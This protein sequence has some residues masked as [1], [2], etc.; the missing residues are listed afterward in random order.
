MVQ[1]KRWSRA[2]QVFLEGLL[3]VL[4]A[5]VLLDVVV[6][7]VRALRGDPLRSTGELPGDLADPAEVVTGALSGTVLVEDPTT[8]QYVWGLVPVVVLL[9]LAV[10]AARLLLGVVRSLRSGD[11]FTSA[12]ARRLSALA[13]L[14]IIGGIF[15]PFLQGIAHEAVLQPVSA[16]AAKGLSVD[17]HLWPAVAGILIGFLAEV[18]ARGARLREDVEGLV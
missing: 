1:V 9:A 8:A 14:V 5:V 15:H 13:G 16:E 6:R 17:L 10:A 2:D 7:V 4:P 18:F 3:W 12:N 11:P